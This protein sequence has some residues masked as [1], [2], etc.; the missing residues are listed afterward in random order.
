MRANDT[1]ECIYNSLESL[2]RELD[3]LADPLI[4]EK[5]ACSLDCCI[6]NSIYRYF[7][8][9]QGRDDLSDKTDENRAALYQAI[10]AAEGIKMAHE[11]EKLLYQ[12]G[13]YY[14][15]KPGFSQELRW[16]KLSTLAQ[17]LSEHIKNSLRK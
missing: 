14:D 17:Q 13:I 11:F 3:F 1:I 12:E 15:D 4:E 5:M 10:I 16:K 6:G 8:S 2:C 7:D 9:I